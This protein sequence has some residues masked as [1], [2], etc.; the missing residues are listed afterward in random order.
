M[1][2]ENIDVQAGGKYRDLSPEHQDRLIK[3]IVNVFEKGT[4]HTVLFRTSHFPN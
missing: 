4:D 3:I 1:I 2:R